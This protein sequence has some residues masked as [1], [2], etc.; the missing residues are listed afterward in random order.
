MAALISTPALSSTRVGPFP[1][2]TCDAVAGPPQPP[3]PAME[4]FR[5][6][7]PDAQWWRCRYGDE[8]VYD[9]ATKVTRTAR[10]VCRGRMHRIWTEEARPWS[11]AGIRMWTGSGPCPAFDPLRSDMR[12]LPVYGVGAS[13][14]GPGPSDADF[15]GIARLM[16][17]RGGL[18]PIGPY[19]IRS[20]NARRWM[21]GLWRTYQLATEDGFTYRFL[22][23]GKQVWLR[24]VISPD[25]RRADAAA[26][27][28]CRDP[29]R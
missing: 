1:E 21:F 14:G 23:I 3:L 2:F 4:S 17:K 29:H 8:G 7:V 19:S 28:S 27:G 22:A 9:F 5:R 15:L 16:Q 26:T 18:Q 11:A 13:D 10:N 25:C 6:K 24:K 20:M 12:Y